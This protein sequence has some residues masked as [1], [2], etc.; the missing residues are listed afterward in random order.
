MK[1]T[2]LIPVHI[3]QTVYVHGYAFL[4]VDAWLAVPYPSEGGRRAAYFRGV[5][6]ADPRNDSIRFTSYNGGVYG[7]GF[8]E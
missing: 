5:C 2:F 7:C 8:I 1:D 3:G 4:V 6:T